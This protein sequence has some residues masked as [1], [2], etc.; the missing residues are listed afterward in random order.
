LDQAL[1]RLQASLETIRQVGSPVLPIMERVLLV[2]LI[3]ALDSARMSQALDQV[4]AGVSAQRARVVI[5]D[6]T[7]VSVVDTAVAQA[8]FQMA[9]GVRLLGAMPVL[10]GIRAEVAQAMVDLGADLRRIATRAGLQE[11]LEYAQEVLGSSAAARQHG[12]RDG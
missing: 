9:R 5:V 12:A 2:P 1:Q 3:G 10:V 4:L 11:G 7:G 8:L 6:I